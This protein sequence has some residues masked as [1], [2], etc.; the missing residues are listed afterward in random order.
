MLR[1]QVTGRAFLRLEKWRCVSHDLR[2]MV[3]L[4]RS[5][6]YR[7]A[8][9]F[10]LLEP[11]SRRLR[12][13]R[14]S[15]SRSSDGPLLPLAD[16][17]EVPSDSTEDDETDD[18]ASEM[19]SA[20]SV[21]RLADL[22]ETRYADI[23]DGEDAWVGVAR[24]SPGMPTSA[25]RPTLR[26]Q[27]SRE[28]VRNEVNKWETRGRTPSSSSEA[29]EDSIDDNHAP[30][31]IRK[32]DRTYR[33]DEEEPRGRGGTIRPSDFLK[34]T[35][36]R[37]RTLSQSSTEPPPYVEALDIDPRTPL[38]RLQRDVSSSTP[39]PGVRPSVSTP[40]LSD[41][42]TPSKIPGSAS[43]P[44][45]PSTYSSS[46]PT[47]REVE[48]ESHLTTLTGKISELESRLKGVESESSRSLAEMARDP[49]AVPVSQALKRTK[50]S[51]YGINVA[52]GAAGLM[53]GMGVGIFL[54]R[55]WAPKP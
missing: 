8:P 50:E 41:D 39:T 1:H 16:L 13:S 40:T 43:H 25:K 38:R 11:L 44:R 34:A 48:L 54:M 27:P 35:R 51:D 29:S 9:F 26:P 22:L 23:A 31:T 3:V 47:E 36:E 37:E 12:R 4:T 42:T 2:T 46:M 17:N 10:P 55:L 32:W 15:L 53:L 5:E 19:S 30:P 21:R 20:S 24:T 52:L 28:S 6:S 49:T 7:T 45:L 33:G 18:G 14:Q